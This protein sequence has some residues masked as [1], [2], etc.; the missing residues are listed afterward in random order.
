M[1]QSKQTRHTRAKIT[2]LRSLATVKYC[3]TVT[4]CIR[5]YQERIDV[6]S[7]CQF[8]FRWIYYCHCSKSTRK[9]TGKTHLSAVINFF[10]FQSENRRNDFLGVSSS[11]QGSQRGLILLTETVF[12]CLMSFPSGS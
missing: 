6:F 2:P 8:F 10:K 7:Q 12:S 11:S 5:N 3:S 9:E 4:K 1:R